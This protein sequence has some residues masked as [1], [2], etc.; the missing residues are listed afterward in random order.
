LQLEAQRKA[1]RALAYDD[2]LTAYAIAENQIE[3]LGMPKLAILPSAQALTG[4]TWRAL[5]KY[6]SDGGNLLIT[7]PVEHDEHWHS[8][9]RTEDLKLGA[10]TTTEPLVIHSATVRIG[11]RVLQLSF[12]QQKQSWLNVLRFDDGSTFKEI[13]YGKGRIFWAAYPVEMAEGSDATADLYSYV[14]AKAGIAPLYD[15]LAPISPGVLVYPVVLEDSVMYVME[16]DSADDTNIDL[17][18]K[19]TETHVKLR[20][21]AQRAAIALVRKQAKAVVAKYGY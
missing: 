18:D 20:L 6:A 12:D 10:K 21:P 2:H 14:A 19:L 5:L 4:Q 8:A 11:D 17:R 13:S 7:G 15:M 9:A 1:V 16:S 3:K